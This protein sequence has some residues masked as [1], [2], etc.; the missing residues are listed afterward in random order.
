LIHPVTV[1][2][3]TGGNATTHVQSL[4]DR[5]NGARAVIAFPA[6]TFTFSADL[7]IKRCS[8]VGA[9]KP[10]VSGGGGTTLAFPGGHGIFSSVQDSSAGSISHMAITGS[11][12]LALIG[13]PLVDLT[14]QGNAVL[15]ELRL[16]DANVGVRLKQGTAVECNYTRLHGVDTL[17]C[18]IGIDIGDDVNWG[19]NSHWIYGGRSWACDIGMRVGQ[20]V[21]N[22][23]WFGGAFEASDTAGVLSAGSNISFYGTRFETDTAAKSLHVLAAAELSIISGWHYLFGCH[24]SSGD[25]IF[26]ETASGRVYGIV[27]TVDAMRLLGNPVV[28]TPNGSLRRLVWG[29]DGSVTTAPI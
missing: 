22:V 25:D 29:N 2:A 24:M 5:Q 11:G 13:S 26:D 18:R 16:I 17:R 19:C 7:D 27:Y 14:G 9:G 6:G 15:H 4:I 12:P 3:I 21:D 23:A 1:A 10:P 20:H 8:L 28:R